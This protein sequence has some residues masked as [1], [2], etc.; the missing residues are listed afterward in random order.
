MFSRGLPP[1]AQG[2]NVLGRSHGCDDVVSAAECL[3][4]CASFT[5]RITKQGDMYCLNEQ[6]RRQFL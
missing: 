1:V 4:C 6:N 3:C 5:S 2:D